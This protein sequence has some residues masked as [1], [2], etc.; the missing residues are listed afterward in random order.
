MA[1]ASG[2]EGGSRVGR[3]VMMVKMQEGVRARGCGMKL[4]GKG[5]KVFDFEV[6]SAFG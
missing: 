6:R 2:A 5:G 3:A 4:N 1:E